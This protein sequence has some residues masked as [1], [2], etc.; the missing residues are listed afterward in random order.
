[1]NLGDHTWAYRKLMLNGMCC[2][3]YWSIYMIRFVEAL[4]I[5]T[6]I[7]NT[8][9]LVMDFKENNEEV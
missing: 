7:H 4:K 5:L 2:T 3:D 9:Y 6:R 1:M 8:F